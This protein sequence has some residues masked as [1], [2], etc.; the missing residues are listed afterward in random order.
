MSLTEKSLLDIY[1]PAGEEQKPR[2]EALRALYVKRFQTEPTAF[3][4]APGRV[5]LGGNH[6]DH[7]GGV[8][9]SASVN[10]D[11]I[12]A[13]DPRNDGKICLISEGF[14]PIELLLSDCVCRK[15]EEGTT[16]AL[17]RGMADGL[18]PLASHFPEAGLGGFNACVMGNVPPGSGLSSSAAFEILIGTILWDLYGEGELSSVKLAQIA[19]RA[20][21]VYFGKPCGLLDQISCATGGV[22]S[23]D[24]SKEEPWVRRVSSNLE[25][26]G[27]QLGMVFCG[28][29]HQDL[30][31]EYAAIPRECRM[32]AAYFG[33]ER[34]CDLPEPEFIA[35]LAEVRT[36]FGDRPVLRALHI[37]EE[38]RRALSEAM[39]LLKGDTEGFL[40]LVNASGKSSGMYLQ[41]VTP[42][43]SV[44]HQELLFALGLCEYVLR[45]QGAVRVHGGGFGGTAEVFVPSSLWE[46]FRKQVEA[47]L[48]EGSVA[49]LTISP[50]GGARV[51]FL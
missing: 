38:N 6:T 35:S 27:Y 45:G 19:Q 23:V 43:S 48:G 42:R 47:V 46:S 11:L 9:L 14:A 33:K 22:V 44:S 5:E 21:N 39:C 18:R 30:T 36:L 4:R 17:I 10:L 41:N 24:F 32:I 34:L 1:G 2:Y 29:S 12:A 50:V 20:E 40:R 37:Y 51:K 28:A 15:E 3:Y 13:V 7:Q 26:S 25:E 31:E 49:A 16:N 8:T